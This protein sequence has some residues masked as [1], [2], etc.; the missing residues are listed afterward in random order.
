MPSPDSRYHGEVCPKCSSDYSYIVTTTPR[1][2][3]NR[4][5]VGKHRWIC[6]DCDNYFLVKAR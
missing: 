4:K 5:I 3:K 1:D 6:N 2:T